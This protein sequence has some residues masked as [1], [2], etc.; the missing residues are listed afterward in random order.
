MVVPQGTKLPPNAAADSVLY[1]PLMLMAYLLILNHLG[2]PFE[3]FLTGWR[4]PLVLCSLGAII[5][6]TSG[7]VRELKTSIGLTLTGFVLWMLAATPAST[8]RGGSAQYTL[9]YVGLW[10]VFF[11]VLA[12]AAKSIPDIQRLGVV[13]TLASLTYIVVGSNITSGRLA[14]EGTFG[15]SDDIALMAGF[16]IPF[17][18]L[19]ASRLGNPLIRRLVF[20]LGVGALLYAVGLTATRAALPSLGA[21]VLVYLW[22]NSALQ[23]VGI[24]AACVFVV[25]VMLIALPGAVLQRFSTIFESLDSRS[26]AA[27]G[28]LSEATASTLI[29]KDLW[30]DAIDTTLTHPVL[31]VGPGQFVEYRFKNYRREDGRSKAYLPAHNTYLEVSTEMGLPGLFLYLTF[32]IL[33]YSRI[34][35]G[36]KVNAS[37][38]HPEWMAGRQIAVCLEAALAYFVVCAVF[39]TGERHPQQFI[40][41]GLALALERV[42]RSLMKQQPVP[43]MLNRSAPAKWPALATQRASFPSSRSSSPNGT[44]PSAFQ[45]P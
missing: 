16:A 8:W 37:G 38:S 11:L 20:A 35:K 17:V 33:V 44:F 34:R 22:R 21:M 43:V 19:L 30:A 36:L 32:L 14:G 12:A 7:A 23:R 39:V 2:R 31:G 15:N 28:Y 29:R 13:I 9:Y 18:V 1:N 42:S 3:F 5:A 45:R 24:L 41:A 27:R 40:I 4:I 10:P 25:L 6:F 26:L